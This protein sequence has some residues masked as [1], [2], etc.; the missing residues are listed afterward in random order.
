MTI[1]ARIERPL[2][3]R[4]AA[5]GDFAA[6]WP[7]FQ[8]VIASGTTYVFDPGTSREDAHAYWFGPGVSSVRDRR[9]RTRGGHVQARREPA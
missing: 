5:E 8:A 7:I 9:G 1:R 2:N 4:R 6:M 3:I